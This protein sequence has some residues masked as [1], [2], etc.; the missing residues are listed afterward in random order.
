VK[1]R[2]W[3]YQLLGHRLVGG[4]LAP[5]VLTIL[6]ILD[7]AQRSHDISGAVAEVG[8]HHGKL[9][10][11]LNLLQVGDEKSVAIDVFG[12]QHLNVDNSG[13]G[14]LRI[15]ERNLTRWSPADRVRLHRG[16]STKLSSETL[17]EIAEARIRLFSVDGG[18]AE[19]CVVSDMHLAEAT[20][21]PGGVVVADDVFNEEW[22]EVLAGTLRYMEDGGG[23]APFA[24]GFNKV[25]FAFPECVGPY[26]ETLSAHL[27]GRL[28]INLKMADF[29]KNRVLVVSR[30]PR[31]R[32]RQWHNYHN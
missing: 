21:A 7:L 17:L 24:I 5:E 28:L 3:L 8:V 29:M 2:F 26:R 19:E 16:D 9:F 23:L 1:L 15:F 32:I 20:L 27:G 12:D 14:D 18:H 11:A 4:W 31:N 22:P 10:N 6:G 25:F 13:R 30:T